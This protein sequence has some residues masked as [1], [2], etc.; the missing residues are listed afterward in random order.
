MTIKVEMFYDFLQQCRESKIGNFQQVIVP[1]STKFTTDGQQQFSPLAEDTTFNLDT[2]R[3]IDP[4]KMLYYYFRER[5]YPENGK[6]P[7]RLIVGAKACDIAA[8][9]VLDKAMDNDDF[10]D[11]NYKL[12]RENTTI[13]SADC[14]EICPTCHC[15]L[16]GG[17]PFVTEGFDLNLS[18][19][20]GNYVMT[21]GSK[22][23]KELLELIGKNAEIKESDPGDIEKQRKEIVTQLE[24]QNKS[25]ARS[26]VYEKYRSVDMDSWN[27]NSKACIGCGACTNICPTCYCLIL[28][29]ETKGQQ[30]TKVRSY[31]S[32][33]LSGYARV[34]G[35]GTPRPKMYQR[36]RNRYLCKFDYMKSNFNMIG[37][38]G[39][40]RCTEACAAKID[41]REVVHN[42]DATVANK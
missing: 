14:T 25:Y 12:W 2:Y 23:G 37:C 36:F 9:R 38:T 11:P 34:A 27:D 18:R 35:G 42:V 15:T 33:Q 1:A 10:V 31:D 6:T 3:T 32:C 40:G 21:T 24:R 8:M 5:V 28:N 41:F 39:C 22:K 7:K 16:V 26:G 29:D 20:N 13:V 19:I 4:L 17:K 30:F